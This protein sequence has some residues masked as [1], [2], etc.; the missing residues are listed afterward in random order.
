MTKS[1]RCK[2][3]KDVLHVLVIHKL[4]T[5]MCQLVSIC[6]MQFID[7]LSYHNAEHWYV[8]LHFSLCIGNL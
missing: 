3:Q 6:L 5:Y 2:K 7:S 4:L 8:V 1:C